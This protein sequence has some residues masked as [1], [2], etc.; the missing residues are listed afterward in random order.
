MRWLK[1]AP[2]TCAGRR[3]AAA[4]TRSAS[5]LCTAKGFSSSTCSP[6]LSAASASAA[7]VGCGVAISTAS[8][9][10]DFSSAAGSVKTFTPDRLGCR[11]GVLSATAVSVRRG[12]FPARICAAWPAPM[13]P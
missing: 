4:T 5:A 9:S 7:C 13:L 11:P 8:T 3:F 1:T 10:P 2:N 12:I 6:A